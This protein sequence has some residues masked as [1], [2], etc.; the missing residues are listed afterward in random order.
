MIKKRFGDLSSLRNQTGCS[1]EVLAKV[2]CHNLCVLIQELFLLGIEI[3]F[4]Q[5]AKEIAQA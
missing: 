1:N 3:N 4:A 2:L 5:L